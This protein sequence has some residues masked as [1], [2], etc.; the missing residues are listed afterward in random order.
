MTDL[1]PTWIGRFG[2]LLPSANSVL[3]RDARLV[4]PTEI[5]AHFSRMKLT[6]DTPDQLSRLAGLAPAAADLVADASLDAMAFTCT[7]GSLDGGLG[8]DRRITEALEE[9]TGVPS[10]TTATAMIEGLQRVGAAEIALVSPYEPWLNDKVVAFLSSHGIGTTNVF[11]F[12]V[13][14]ADY[15]RQVTPSQI[16]DTVLGMD[17]GDAGAVFISCTGFRGIEAV[18]LLIGKLDVP[19]LTSNQVTFWKLAEMTDFLDVM[20]SGPAPHLFEVLR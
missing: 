10:T 15:I 8:Y 13:P 4:M 11:G 17:L 14:E 3:E 12:G 19:I 1:D 7:T 16:A 9:A 20:V 18:E 2:L 6:A 5:T